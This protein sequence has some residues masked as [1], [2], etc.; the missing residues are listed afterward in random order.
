MP[1]SI[2]KIS[3]AVGAVVEGVDL[4]DSSPIKGV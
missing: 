2:Q 1:I 4:S 3:P